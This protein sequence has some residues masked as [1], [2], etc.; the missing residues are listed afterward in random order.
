M[1]KEI[2]N[3]LPDFIFAKPNKPESPEQ[4][5]EP[6]PCAICYCDYDNG[7]QLKKLPCKH[8]FHSHCIKPWVEQHDTCPLCRKQIK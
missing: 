2:Y 5:D 4:K 7:E 1:K 6:Q 3:N 8:E